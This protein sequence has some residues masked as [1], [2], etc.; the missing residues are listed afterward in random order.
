MPLSKHLT[1]KS[2]TTKHEVERLLREAD[3]PNAEVDW[4]YNFDKK[5]PYQILNMGNPMLMGG[6]HWVAVD[7]THK[8]YFDP[9]GAS[10]PEYIPKNYEYSNLQVQ[11]FN[12]GRCGQYSVLFLKYSMADEVDRFFNLFEISNL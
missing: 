5:I 2:M 4:A 7:N 1:T 12:W 8:R 11:D 3:I 6:T 9:L 10:P